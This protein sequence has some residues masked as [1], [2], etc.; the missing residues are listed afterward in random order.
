M[1]M[2]M[3]GKTSF[4]M[5]HAIRREASIYVWF[6]YPPDIQVH[7]KEINLIFIITYNFRS[8]K[9]TSISYQLITTNIWRTMEDKPCYGPSLGMVFVF[10]SHLPH[11][12]F[13]ANHL[14]RFK[15]SSPS[16]LEQITEYLLSSKRTVIMLV[17]FLSGNR[18]WTHDTE[19]IYSN[20]LL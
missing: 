16:V 11:S 10:I 19:N 18:R 12:I 7:V 15:I 8:L 2:S 13:R 5:N 3:Y 14:Q 9:M 20:S 1:Y 4:Y 6:K 17:E